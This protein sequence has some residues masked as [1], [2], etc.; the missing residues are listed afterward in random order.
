MSQAYFSKFIAGGNITPTDQVVGVRNGI[1]TIFNTASLPTF[2]ISMVQGGTGA[3]LVPS[4]NCLVYSTAAALALLPTVDS[5][6]LVTSNTGVP[7]IS[8]TPFLNNASVNT[9][10]FLNDDG[11]LDANG[12]P[13]L[14]LCNT[15]VNP[16]NFLYVCNNVAGDPPGISSDGQ[17]ASVGITFIPKA[18]G[19]VGVYNS[20]SAL[21]IPCGT[22]A[23][24]P[25]TAV[26]GYTRIN[27]DTG[28]FE[29]VNALTGNW[30]SGQRWNTYSSATT[31]ATGNGYIANNNVSAVVFTLPA[32]SSIGD[33]Y[34]IVSNTQVGW[35]INQ[36]N[37][38]TI[39]LG[40]Q[41]TTT[42]SGGYITPL[43][44]VN[45]EAKALGF[46]IEIICSVANTE[47][48]ACMKQGNVT[49]Y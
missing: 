45:S 36:N 21:K 23:Q 41:A 26:N 20:T 5:G 27:A 7:S 19:I 44:P 3:S 4:I 1:N 24:R 43:Y 22:T 47:F 2:P 32:T 12:L 49:L 35:Q 15:V 33:T 14:S 40:D 6:V 10:K 30:S 48:L 42:G 39:Q 25:S 34:Q 38:Q 29:Y 17:D 11:I 28:L 16:V 18:N 46:W 8:Q 13:I 9:L 31:L 37:T